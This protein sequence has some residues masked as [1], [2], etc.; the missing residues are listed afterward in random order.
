MG[1]K[2]PSYERRHRLSKKLRPYYLAAVL[3]FWMVNAGY[4]FGRMGNMNRDIISPFLLI[5]SAFFLGLGVWWIRKRIIE[6][7][8]QEHETT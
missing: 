2:D 1:E 7:D 3:T 8:R 5:G 6:I 4:A